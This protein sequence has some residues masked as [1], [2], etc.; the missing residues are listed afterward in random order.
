[1]PG[2]GRPVVN[3]SGPNS[4]PVAMRPPSTPVS[5][6][7]A[8]IVA[9]VQHAAHAVARAPVMHAPAPRNRVEQGVSAVVAPVQHTA[10]SIT[11]AVAPRPAPHGGAGVTSHIGSKLGGGGAGPQ[12]AAVVS[13]PGVPLAALLKPAGGFLGHLGQDLIDFPKTTV[14]GT[15]ALG[16][17]LGHDLLHPTH[18]FQS[19]LKL[20]SEM[21]KNDALFQLLTLHP[22]KALKLA[23]QHPL[24]AGL[25]LAGGAGVLGRGLGAAGRLGGAEA[26]ALTR[27]AR[28]ILGDTSGMSPALRK[29]TDALAPVERRASPNLFTSMIQ[30]GLDVG[31]PKI[32]PALNKRLFEHEMR[33]RANEHQLVR[34]DLE[35]RYEAAARQARGDHA[36]KDQ[37]NRAR[38][39]ARS[40]ATMDLLQQNA[41]RNR[42]TGGVLFGASTTPKAVEQLAAHGHEFVKVRAGEL[43]GSR[44][45]GSVV[46]PKAL[47]D[48]LKAHELA[49]NV[50]ATAGGRAF[51]QLQRQFRNSVLPFSTKWIVGNTAEAALRSGLEGV[52]PVHI[53][54]FNRLI[55]EMRAEGLGTQADRLEA[56]GLQGTHFSL[57]AR[58]DRE[59]RTRE[60][61]GGSLPTRAAYGAAHKY[62]ALPDLI[63]RGNSRVEQQFAKAVLGKHIAQTERMLKAAHP[64]L[65][66]A[67][68]QAR[69][70]HHYSRPEVAAEAG[71]YSRRV[72]GKYSGFGPTARQT[73][74]NIAPFSPWYANAAKFMGTL[75]YRHPLFSGATT[76]AARATDKQWA[77]QHKPIEGLGGSLL[78]MPGVGTPPKG[79]F[80]GLDIGRYTPM[81]AFAAGTGQ[82]FLKAAFADALPAIGPQWQGLFQN[83]TGRDPFNQ[84]LLYPG[85]G[86][87]TPTGRVSH[88]KS[89]PI[90]KGQGDPE[91]AVSNFLGSILGPANP[92]HRIVV[93]RGGTPYNTEKLWDFSPTMKSGGVPL[94]LAAI[95]AGLNRVLNPIRPT[96]VSPHGTGKKGSSGRPASIWGGG[97][98]GSHSKHAASIWG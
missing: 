96:V 23:G 86:D 66:P 90:P 68:L 62:N 59:L 80:S 35:A 12:L 83:L 46:I 17:A 97:S 14:Q 49:S 58:L 40:Q 8:S 81:G 67:E 45:R 41:V 16:G 27:T 65:T 11:H 79:G 5:R 37:I 78:Q 26:A 73:V 71:R 64:D 91:T 34:Q 76:N 72:L 43:L 44:G 74:R 52:H 20:G 55:D 82:P 88:A 77:A 42:R 3:P 38:A 69:V 21:A 56:Q 22:D 85:P 7:V 19:T 57:N 9:P 28:P 29:A 36:T 6:G 13:H 31:I 87:K 54:A 84:T 24:G 2:I 89:H 75:P 48:Q 53:A 93:D 39:R 95:V 18:P 92:I 94:N 70:A 4:R 50:G 15:A 51:Q 32:H 98:G 25:D 30:R 1:M 60:H 33:V 47:H 10:H 61:Q 63:F